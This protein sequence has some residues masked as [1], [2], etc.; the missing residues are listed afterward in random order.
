M[1]ICQ[2]FGVNHKKGKLLEPLPSVKMSLS[3]VDKQEE[4]VCPPV[5]DILSQVLIGYMSNKVFVS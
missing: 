1:L 5:S 4:C 2:S 3:Q